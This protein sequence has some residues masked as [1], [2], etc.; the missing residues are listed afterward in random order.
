VF[1]F[2]QSHRSASWPARRKR[3][4]ICAFA[5]PSRLCGKQNTAQKTLQQDDENKT[6][7]KKLSVKT[8]KQNT[9]QKTQ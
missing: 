7:H 3:D 2:P 1:S 5:L 6:P 9:A 4:F 8:T